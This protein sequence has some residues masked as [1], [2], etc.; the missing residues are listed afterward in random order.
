MPVCPGP[1]VLG[2]VVGPVKHKVSYINL[3]R[4]KALRMANLEHSWECFPAHQGW[5]NRFPALTAHSDSHTVCC[6]LSCHTDACASCDHRSSL[7]YTYKYILQYVFFNSG[8]FQGPSSSSVRKTIV[9]ITLLGELQGG[10]KGWDSTF[11]A[12][13]QRLIWDYMLRTAATLWSGAQTKHNTVY[14]WTSLWR[15]TI[16]KLHPR[17][18]YHTWLPSAGCVPRR[19][20]L[21]VLKWQSDVCQ[22]LLSALDQKGSA[23]LQNAAALHSSLVFT[24]KLPSTRSKNRI[25]TFPQVGV[26]FQKC[27]WFTE[28]TDAVTK[29][30]YGY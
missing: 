13:W 15:I 14:C 26:F 9:L 24:W 19:G 16:S 30:G 21:H 12:T 20:S 6:P 17:P 4:T 5:L 18:V 29:F 28:L 10:W 2:R 1:G 7:S 27:L 3:S 23:F 8:P 11:L 22:N 25:W